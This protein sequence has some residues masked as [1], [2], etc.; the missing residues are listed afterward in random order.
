MPGLLLGG[1]LLLWGRPAFAQAWDSPAADAVVDLAVARRA[2]VD[3]TL[4]AWTGEG[5]G[6]LQFL[7]ELGNA[8]VLPPRVVK[9]VELASKVGPR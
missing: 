6:N 2:H 4:K 8:T 9:L 5:A 7:V 1:L 3:S